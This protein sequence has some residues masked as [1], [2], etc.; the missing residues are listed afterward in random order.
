MDK[1][2]PYDQG[3]MN[4]VNY[5]AYQ[6]PAIRS[7]CNEWKDRSEFRRLLKW[8]DSELIS[9]LVKNW[10]NAD[11]I[12][13]NRNTEIL[14]QQ[15]KLELENRELINPSNELKVENDEYLES[16]RGEDG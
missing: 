4:E 15:K 8:Y 16:R 6:S 13:G 9:F 5:R 12:Q 2:K 1:S 7:M 14:W 11:S 10:K 3:G